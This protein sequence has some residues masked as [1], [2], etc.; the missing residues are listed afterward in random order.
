MDHL[1]EM[2][3]KSPRP[4][5][6]L[7]AELSQTTSEPTP[8]PDLSLGLG[9]AF[10]THHIRSSGA[11]GLRAVTEIR[12]LGFN[13][14]LLCDSVQDSSFCLEYFL[15]SCPGGKLLL[16]LQDPD[17]R[18]AFQISPGILSCMLHKPHAWTA[19]LFLE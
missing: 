9:V 12:D 7:W 6:K 14:S 10:K 1:S 5:D 8:S 3:P 19:R 4:S 15:P 18:E 11:Q 2:S 13:G 16:I 17:V